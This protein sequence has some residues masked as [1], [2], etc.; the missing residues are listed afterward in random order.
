MKLKDRLA[1][2]RAGYSKDEIAL[3]IEEDKN[4]E[5]VEQAKEEASN[6]EYP[7]ALVALAN[8]VKNL[9]ETFQA[10]N[11]DQVETIASSN[12][13]NEAMDILEGLINPSANKKEE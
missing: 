2:L 8:E 13:V 12:K 3:L 9:K 4:V 5:E 6:K 10:S 1:L 7:D 11:R